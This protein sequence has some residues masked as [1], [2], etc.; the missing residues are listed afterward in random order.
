MK[1]RQDFGLIAEQLVFEQGYVAFDL[2]D[3]SAEVSDVSFQPA[4]PLA[5]P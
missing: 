3:I 2:D 4:K 1:D 5:M